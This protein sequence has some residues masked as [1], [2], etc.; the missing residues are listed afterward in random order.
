MRKTI[1]MALSAPAFLFSLPAATVEERCAARDFLLAGV[2][3]IGVGGGAM[4]GGFIL[5]GE[6]VF[7]LAESRSRNGLV[8]YAAVGAF[9]GKGRAVYLAH[10]AYLD[11]GAAPGG[12]RIL[13]AN[14]VRWMSHGKARPKIAALRSGRI[15][16]QFRKLGFED[17]CVV[18]SVGEATGSDV[19]ISNEVR[20]E[21]VAAILSFARSGGGFLNGSLGWGFMCIHPSACFSEDFPLNRISG[22]MGALM[23][24]SSVGC[25]S[26]FPAVRGDPVFGTCV[27]DAFAIVLAGDGRTKADT[28]QAAASLSILI[29]ALPPG[30]RPELHRKLKELSE[31]PEARKVPSPSSPVGP[32]DACARIAIAARKNAWLADPEKPVPAESAA[33]VYPGAVKPGTPK[34]DRRVEVDLS[35]PRWHST[36]VFAVAG[37]PLT[38][39]IGDDARSSGLKV[40]IGSTAD[41]LSGCAA[42]KRAPRVTCEVPLSKAETTV[43]NPF[44]GLVYIV[45]PERRELSGSVRVGISGGVM[46]PWFRLGRDTHSSFAEQCRTTGAPYGEIQ[47]HDFIVSAETSRLKEIDDAEWIAR[48]WDRVLAASQD[49]AQWESRRYPERMCSD[50]QLT[51]GFMHSGYPLMTHIN[52]DGLDWAIDRARLEK[53]EAWGCYH[54]IGHNHQNRDWTPDGTV[55]VTVNLFTTHAIETVVGADIREDRFHSGRRPMER[56]VREWV[57]KGKTFAAWKK[58]P[59]LALEMYLR[60]K[61]AYGWEVFKNTFARYRKPGFVRPRDDNEKWQVFAKEIS[62]SAGANLAAALAKWSIPVNGETLTECSVYP[63]APAAVTAGLGLRRLDK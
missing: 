18:R 8:E 31:R 9:Y 17:V 58:D 6:D 23:S 40:R 62:R 33:A 11:G 7:P 60:I 39:T 27:D 13:L 15:A 3:S 34:I 63:D 10:T 54:E 25:G 52:S 56:R 12:T 30:V 1:L 21:D 55:E 46:A 44:G 51:V 4:P 36:G 20:K 26:M 57:A 29:A 28:M 37:E 35:V 38:V 32:E 59:F 47:G 2:D 48:Y 49:L 24:L 19:L 14:S 5:A 61:E 16:D 41:D 45:V 43:Y 22:E 53:G 42:W 50:V